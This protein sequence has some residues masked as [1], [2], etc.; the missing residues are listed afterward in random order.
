MKLIKI[1][2]HSEPCSIGFLFWH[3][4]LNVLHIFTLLATIN[5]NVTNMKILKREDRLLNFIFRQIL[6]QSMGFVSQILETSV[7][8]VPE[9]LKAMTPRQRY[10]VLTTLGWYHWKCQ[11]CKVNKGRLMNCENDRLS[12]KNVN[13]KFYEDCL[14]KKKRKP[15]QNSFLPLWVC[16]C[17]VL[18]FL[19]HKVS[20]RPDTKL[21]GCSVFG[22][23]VARPVWIIKLWD[24]GSR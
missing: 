4:W 7:F 11:L 12:I 22:I 13:R 15:S 10:L 21:F 19:F 8:D 24:P 2:R 6:Y 16:V 18:L 3:K 9:L 14:L 1:M 17:V 20:W 23:I 5:N